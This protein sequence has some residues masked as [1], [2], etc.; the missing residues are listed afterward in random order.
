MG[1]YPV[2]FQNTIKVSWEYIK[3]Y[4]VLITVNSILI[5]G[6]VVSFRKFTCVVII[7]ALNIIKLVSFGTEAVGKIN[8]KIVSIK[9]K[10]LKGLVICRPL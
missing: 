5:A 8:D 4:G 2:F 1:Y 7:W 3:E 9:K 6:E 10:E